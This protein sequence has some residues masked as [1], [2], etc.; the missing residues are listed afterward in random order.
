M[1]SVSLPP[2]MALRMLDALVR[3]V[4]QHRRESLAE[5]HVLAAAALQA[6]GQLREAEGHFLEAK[7]WRAAA[8][9]YRWGGESLAK[10]GMTQPLMA[11]L[12]AGT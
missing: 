3:L 11:D 7:D 12:T 9:M 5:A 6:A 10:P 1:H 4:G 2:S 8:A